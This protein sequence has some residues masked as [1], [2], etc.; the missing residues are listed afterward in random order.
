[1]KMFLEAA[2]NSSA[3]ENLT[4]GVLGF[5]NIGSN[6]GN[7]CRSELGNPGITELPG[8]TNLIIGE[9]TFGDIEQDAMKV[10]SMFIIFLSTTFGKKPVLWRLPTGRSLSEI[11]EE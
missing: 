5:G 7:E 10:I 4:K 6:V 2:A 9:N 11:I 3:S 8:T 1:M